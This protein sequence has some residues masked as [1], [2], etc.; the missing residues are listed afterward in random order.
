MVIENPIRFGLK[1]FLVGAAVGLTIG[2]GLMA[3]GIC[4]PL[5]VIPA[6]LIFVLANSPL[7]AWAGTYATIA[8]ISSVSAL[9]LVATAAVLETMDRVCTALWGLSK[10]LFKFIERCWT[11]NSEDETLNETSINGSSPNGSSPKNILSALGDI[12]SELNSPGQSE[13]NRSVGKGNQGRR[14]S[15]ILTDN[16][17]EGLRSTSFSPTANQSRV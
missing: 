10:N 3:S 15:Y 5:L 7:F 1:T 17:A 13:L 4:P 6:V 11:K 2:I 12:P 8:V 9:M 14:D 16:E